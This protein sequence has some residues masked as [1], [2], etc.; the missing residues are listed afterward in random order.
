MKNVMRVAVVA[1]VGMAA[2]ASAQEP[3]RLRLGSFSILTP[4]PARVVNT[5]NPAG[6]AATVYEAEAPPVKFFITFVRFS[7]P[8]QM[9]TPEQFAHNMTANAQAQILGIWR[10]RLA[11][12]P[13][14]KVLY[15]IGEMTVM[16]WSVQPD[17]KLNY[18]LS[19]NG[20][21][22]PRYRNSA[23]QYAASFRVEGEHAGLK[24]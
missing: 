11:G 22:S 7:F 6:E 2:V 24:R 9:V 12:Y 19:V 3:T 8:Q 13:A 4:A 17:P 23:I 18:I 5:Q 20:P 16:A 1:I 14:D 21:D 15:R 10:D